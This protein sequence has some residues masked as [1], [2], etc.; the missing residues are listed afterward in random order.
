M[1]GSAAVLSISDTGLKT[2]RALFTAPSNGMAVKAKP[3]TTMTYQAGAYMEPADCCLNQVN[4]IGAKPPNRVKAPLYREVPVAL[5]PAG[6]IYDSA[7][8]TTP[9]K[10]ATRIHP[11]CGALVSS[12][13]SLKGYV[14][15]TSI[16]TLRA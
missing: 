16:A 11:P 6:N 12:G 5:T 8:G 1:A 15:V 4:I 3:A 10:L 9:T 7:A 2:R 13:R 14:A